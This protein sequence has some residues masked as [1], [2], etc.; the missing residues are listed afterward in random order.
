MPKR[1][2]ASVRA[3]SRGLGDYKAKRDFSKTA[4]PAGKRRKAAG[5]SFVVQEHHARSHHFDFRLEMDGVLVSWAVPKGVPEDLSAKRL[6]VHVEDH[7]LDYGNFEG[8]IPEGNYGAGTVAIWDKG[9]WTPVSRTW[10]KD[11][12]AGKLKFHLHGTRLHG[13]YL[14]VRSKDEPDWFFRKLSEEGPA[15]APGRPGKPG[16]IPFHLAKVVPTV[17]SGDDWLH[18]IKLDGYRLMAVKERGEI[19]LFTRNGHDWSDRFRDLPQHISAL[20]AKDFV[21][22]GEAV[23]FDSKGRSDFGAL[24]AALKPRSEAKVTFVVF[25]LLHLDGINLRPARPVRAAGASRR[26]ANRRSRAGAPLQSLACGERCRALQRGMQAGTRGDHF[27]EGKRTL[28][29]RPAGMDEVQ[30]PATAGVH[31]LRVFAAEGIPA[32]FRFAGAGDDREREA[33]PAGQGG[34]RLPG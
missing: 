21:L 34:H 5:N 23:V 27:E 29:A 28:H 30:V 18:E 13:E 3:I 20:S 17:P 16:F 6:A 31:R 7:P 15:A 24:Q 19:R 32:G 2:I 14:L 26:T 12:A 22:D 10:R 1:S 4:E 8:E 25:D 9:S 33:R 11:F